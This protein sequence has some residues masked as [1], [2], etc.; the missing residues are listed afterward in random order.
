[1]AVALFAV[2]VL[3]TGM[4]ITG[5]LPRATGLA[6]EVMTGSLLC[7]LFAASYLYGRRKDLFWWAGLALIPVIAVTR[8]GIIASGLT[9]PLTFGPMKL[10]KRVIFVMIIIIAGL[11]LFQTERIQQKMFYSGSGTIGDVTLENPD[12]ATGGRTRMWENMQHEI[13]KM[14]WFGHGANASEPFVVLLTG[15]LAHPH[16]DWLRL[17]Y[18]YGYVGTAIFA[19]TVFFQVLHLLKMG[20]RSSG[21]RRVLFFAGATSF[22]V[23]CLFMFTDNIIL[24]AAFFGNLQFT[25]IG[26]AYASYNTAL[27]KTEQATPNQKPLYR[28]ISW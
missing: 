4:L 26:L 24:Y 22:V 14:P 27:S 12:F 25:V 8:A 6:A 16:N 7:T 28:R 2:V 20:R 9:L 23:F 15:G 21:E 19:L 18:D 3:K 10:F 5:T 11:G 17:Q 13:D 1:M